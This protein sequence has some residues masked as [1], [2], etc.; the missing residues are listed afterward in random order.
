MR[1][2]WGGNSYKI[3][4]V[5]ENGKVSLQWVGDNNRGAGYKTN[6][7]VVENVLEELDAP[8]EWYYDKR[9]GKLYFY[10]PLGMD[11][12]EAV[13][14]GA[15][16]SELFRL[17]GDTPDRPIQNIKF[18]GIH[19]TKT[20]RTLFNSVYERPL[21][22]DWGLARTGVL[23][24]ENAKNVAVTN[25]RFDEIGGNAIM[26]SGYNEKHSI[27]SN[28]MTQIGAS[29]V[30]IVGRE[31]A[32]R[33]PS[34][35]DNDDHKTVINDT[36]AGPKSENYPRDIT[37]SNTYMYDLGIYEKQVSGICISIAARIHVK[38]NTIHRCPRAGINISD[39]T[40]GGHL[41]EDNDIFDCVRGTSDH[42]PINAWG[43]DRFW[44]LG[45]YDTR[46]SKGAEKK[47]YAFLDV[48]ERN[49][50][51][52]NRI[53]H[54]SEFG[55]DLDDG[56]SNYE[57]YDNLFLGTGVKLREGFGRTV[58]N[59]IIVN[60]QSIFMYLMREMMMLCKTMLS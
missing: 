44:S 27:D 34:H 47:P 25:C 36:S 49:V 22:G 43:R 60:G 38:G 11:L 32:V 19:F 28:Q 18:T 37:I 8:N 45:G 23:F 16:A 53:S 17:T 31:E 51:R 30:L 54:T 3:T 55:V 7:M 21:R 46:G 26:M 33:D 10:P 57:I 6:Q 9:K 29:A 59:N 58:R 14:E 41:I 1:R 20:H 35:W 5:D 24:M 52:H 12:S 48:I 4:D 39:G 42:G 40:F 13:F 2:E 15:A 50:I 56:S